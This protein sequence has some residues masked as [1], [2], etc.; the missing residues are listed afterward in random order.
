MI[1]AKKFGFVHGLL[2]RDQVDSLMLQLSKR[3]STPEKL[4]Y[5]KYYYS[6]NFNSVSSDNRIAVIYALGEITNGTGM[7]TQSVQRI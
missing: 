7:R 4:S 5:K 1:L 2:Y 3:D 6:S